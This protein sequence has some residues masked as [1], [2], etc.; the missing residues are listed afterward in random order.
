MTLQNFSQNSM[1]FPEIPENLKIPEIPWLFHD[2]GN[3][4]KDLG[5]IHYK[6]GVKNLNDSSIDCVYT[7]YTFRKIIRHFR[8]LS[9]V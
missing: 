3:P 4:D 1:T 5:V 7:R 9:I 2:H 6:Y 8:L